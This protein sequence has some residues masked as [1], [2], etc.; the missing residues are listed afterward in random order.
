M[1]RFKLIS[2]FLISLIVIL[3]LFLVYSDFTGFKSSV[4]QVPITERSFADWIVVGAKEEVIKRVKYDAGYYQISY[5]LGDVDPQIGAC[6]DLVIRALRRA[7]LD[8]QELIHEDMRANFQLYPSRWGL[9]KPDPN[10]DHRRVPNQIVFMRRFGQTL[11]TEFDQQTKDSWRPGDLVYWR[12]SDGRDHVGV[13]S[14][15]T[16]LRGVPLV[17]HNAHITI[18]EDVLLKW[19]IIG[20]YR[21]P[22][23]DD[24]DTVRGEEG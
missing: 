20:H 22:Q 23:E 11:P 18:E 13:I 9:T 17:I 1:N 15:R 8:L 19:E 16:N 24:A 3:I 14:D 7:G 2:I 10:I 5:P 4:Y 6:T 21:Y 12:M